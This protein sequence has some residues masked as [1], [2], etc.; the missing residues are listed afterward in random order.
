M[1]CSIIPP[2]FVRGR[3]AL[4]SPVSMFHS[5]ARDSLQDA[6]DASFDSALDVRKRLEILSEALGRS[7]NAST[8]AQVCTPCFRCAGLPAVTAVFVVF[9]FVCLFF[10]VFF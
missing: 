9:F 7:I 4:N 1:S 3:A 2:Y 10:Y 5:Q 8:D 6:M